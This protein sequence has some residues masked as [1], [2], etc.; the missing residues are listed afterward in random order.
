MKVLQLVDIFLDLMSRR[1]I[2][3]SHAKICPPEP[4]QVDISLDE[5]AT[6]KPTPESRIPRTSRMPGTHEG[7]V[8]LGDWLH[9]CHDASRYWP[10]WLQP[11]SV[12]DIMMLDSG[13][14]VWR[15]CYYPIIRGTLVMMW[16]TSRL[17]NMYINSW[18]DCQHLII[19][20]RIGNFK[21]S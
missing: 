2:S 13:L 14:A 10:R 20:S 1:H 21:M 18:G 15:S 5:G 9:K 12:Q 19:L 4:P 6:T 11:T 7:D 3:V 16:H 8:V 17:P